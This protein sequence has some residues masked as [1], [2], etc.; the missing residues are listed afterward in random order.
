MTP[1]LT[2]LIEAMR[3]LIDVYQGTTG[4]DEYTLRVKAAIKAVETE[5]ESHEAE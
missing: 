4:T 1:Q 2:E 5:G 3:K